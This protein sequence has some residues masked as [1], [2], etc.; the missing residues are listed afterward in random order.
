MYLQINSG[1]NFIVKQEI[2]IGAIPGFVCRK[3]SVSTHEDQ[4]YN[5]VL[6]SGRQVLF[7]LLFFLKVL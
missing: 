7:H 2:P 1:H 5:F 4:T 3:Q 6:L